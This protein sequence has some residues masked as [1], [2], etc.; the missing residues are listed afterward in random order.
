[1]LAALGIC[2]GQPGP[3]VDP[4][5]GCVGPHVG[6]GGSDGFDLVERDSE[7]LELMGAVVEH[8]RGVDVVGVH[9]LSSRS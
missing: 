9:V 3:L 1:M 5:A 6:A 2:L 4:A 8:D 7:F